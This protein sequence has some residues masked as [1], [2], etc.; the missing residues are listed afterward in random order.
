MRREMDLIYSRDRRCD[1]T[2]MIRV[3]TARGGVDYQENMLMK[4]EMKT[5]VKVGGD[6]CFRLLIW[7]ERPA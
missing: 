5:Q 2:L 6:M 7:A 4:G 3:A 1:T